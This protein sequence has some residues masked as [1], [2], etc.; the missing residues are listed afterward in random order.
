MKP[1]SRDNPSSKI[2]R[3]IRP[4]LRRLSSY[5]VPEADSM[6][7]LDAMENPYAWP[8]S[9]VEEWLGELRGVNLNRY[10][11]SEAV[12]LKRQLRD[13]LAVPD[14]MEVLIGNGS[15]E[16]IQMINLS[17][18]MPGRTVLAP[19]PTFSM[20]R[21][22][23]VA[24]GLAFIDVSLDRD[25][26]LDL[27]ATLAAM[28]RHQ[29]AVVYIDYPNNPTGNLFDPARLHAIIEAAPGLVVIDEA[30]HIYSGASFMDQ[31]P[32]YDNLLVLRT[33]SKLG[34][35]GLRLGLMVGPGQW[36]EEI[37]KTRLPYNVGVL[38]QVSAEFA[39]RHKDVLEAQTQKIREDRQRLLDEMRQLEGIIVYPSYA[40]FI[41]FRAVEAPAAVLYEKIRS[42]GVLI[43]NFLNS[44]GILADCLR[45]TVGTPQENE[46]FI[47]ALRQALQASRP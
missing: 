34:L 19:S 32:R 10:P 13:T 47:A 43:R 42:E 7:K 2:D 1:A 44:E 9:L 22:I 21:M 35:A 14:E 8:Q 33:L 45:V 23:A 29:P 5:H 11:D 26:D 30:Y 36:L 39:L 37:N 25:F 16:L 31:L 27:S 24:T 38:A 20:Y 12:A 15:D 46:A 6:I 4:E 18:A 41:L 17:V 40:N 28:E 3:W